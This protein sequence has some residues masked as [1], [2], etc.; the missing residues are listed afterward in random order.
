MACNQEKMG[1]YKNTM[2]VKKK[3]KME[4]RKDKELWLMSENYYY[5]RLNLIGLAC[6]NVRKANGNEEATEDHDNPL[7]Q[8]LRQCPLGYIES[9]PVKLMH[10][11]SIM[12]VFPTGLVSS[13][14][15]TAESTYG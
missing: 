4:V 9:P 10:H 14:F 15:V 7:L 3:T 5:N 13:F 1:G 2:E 11:G 8:R 6:P 12:A